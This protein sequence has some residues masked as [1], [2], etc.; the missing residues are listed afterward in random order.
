[1]RGTQSIDKAVL[2]LAL[3][4]DLTRL[5]G[6]CT[7]FIVTGAGRSPKQAVGM[8]RQ[9][10]KEQVDQAV[11]GRDLACLAG[12]CTGLLVAVHCQALHEPFGS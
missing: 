2:A 8:L 9:Q 5:A 12:L 7:S 3:A 6:L 11:M 1:M 4:R 10:V